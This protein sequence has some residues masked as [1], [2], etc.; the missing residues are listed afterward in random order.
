METEPRGDD[1]GQLGVARARA[2]SAEVAALLAEADAQA[3]W[4]ESQEWSAMRQMIAKHG[5]M[6]DLG[7]RTGRGEGQVAHLVA[8]ARRVRSHAPRSWSAFSVGR[9]DLARVREISSTVSLLQRPE[10]CDRLD[11]VVVDY[12]E[13]ISSPAGPPAT[14]TPAARPFRR[15]KLRSPSSSTPPRWPDSSRVSPSAQT[16]RGRSRT[17]GSWTPH[18]RVTQRGAVCS[19][20]QS[21]RTHSPSSRSAA[22]RQTLSLLRWRLSTGTYVSAEPCEHGP[23]PATFELPSKTIHRPGVEI[24]YLPAAA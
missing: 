11:A 23:P 19:S 10:S 2:E 17:T 24:Y 1:L 9:L 15:P 18:S 22:S 20:I 12:A 3:V 14:L 5:V 8:M 16:D 21:P 13:Q 4:I 6:L 7:Q